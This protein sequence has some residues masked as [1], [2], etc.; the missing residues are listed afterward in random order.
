M[1]KRKKKREANAHAWEINRFSK[2]RDGTKR[3]DPHFARTVFD[4]KF[5][6]WSIPFNGCKMLTLFFVLLVIFFFIS[7]STH[8][9]YFFLRFLPPQQY[10]FLLTHFYWNIENQQNPFPKIAPLTP[11]TFAWFIGYS[12]KFQI[13]KHQQIDFPSKLLH[14]L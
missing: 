4:L 1:A 14:L 10:F 3:K 2:N 5:S 6:A 12:R 7:F 11:C 13:G 9:L 8:I